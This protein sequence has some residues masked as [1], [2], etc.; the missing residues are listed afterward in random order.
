MSV[1]ASQDC[2]LAEIHLSPTVPPEATEHGE[3]AKILEATPRPLVEENKSQQSSES[4]LWL[5]CILREAL[6]LYLLISTFVVSR[7]VYPTAYESF[8]GDALL[9]FVLSFIGAGMIACIFEDTAKMFLVTRF[10]AQGLTIKIT[11]RIQSPRV[12]LKLSSTFSVVIG[13]VS[14]GVWGA[15]AGYLSFFL[16]Q[17]LVLLGAFGIVNLVLDDLMLNSLPESKISITEPEFMEQVFET[18]SLLKK[19]ERERAQLAV[20]DQRALAKA[21]SHEAVV[22]LRNLG[23]LATVHSDK[24]DSQSLHWL[25]RV[26]LSCRQQLYCTQ[27]VLNHFSELMFKNGNQKSNSRFVLKCIYYLSM[28]LLIAIQHVNVINWL[29]RVRGL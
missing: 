19:I 7:Q 3:E 20:E 8:I 28:T 2:E 11:K 16:I 5:Q 10:N 1:A 25:V 14:V 23:S 17:Q 29:I 4:T 22:A 13:V 26:F 18:M 12:V 21:K 9:R 24:I 6:V 27:F 15:H